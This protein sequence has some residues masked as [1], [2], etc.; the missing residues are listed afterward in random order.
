MHSVQKVKDINTNEIHGNINERGSLQMR[1]DSIHLKTW[2]GEE[3]TEVTEDSRTCKV[4][5]LPHDLMVLRDIFIGLMS[6][7]RMMRSRNMQTSFESMKEGVE[8]ASKRRFDEKALFQLK[9]LL[10]DVIQLEKIGENIRVTMSNEQI[11]AKT[12]SRL[13]KALVDFVRDQQGKGKLHVPVWGQSIHQS[14]DRPTEVKRLDFQSPSKKKQ[15]RLSMLCS[16]EQTKA[17]SVSSGRITMDDANLLEAVPRELR[18]RSM[19]GVISIGSLHKLDENEKEHRRLSGA[20][21]KS[22]RLNRAT[23]SSLPDIFQR[24]QVIFGRRGPRVI[25]LDQLC[26]RIRSGGLETI[27]KDDISTRIRCLA[28]HAPEFITIERDSRRDVEEV[29]ISRNKALDYSDILIRLLNVKG[30]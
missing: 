16:L 19:D 8:N 26:D 24:V 22:E 3:C 17:S 2:C 7:Y 18:R 10:P 27:S 20:E 14:N 1:D 23:V 11:G 15:R 6:V 28:E 5:E 13:E 9:T 12:V 4:S 29:W 30:S 21:A 25:R